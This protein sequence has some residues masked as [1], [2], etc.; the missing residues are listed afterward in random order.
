MKIMRRS[1]LATLLLMALASFASAQEFRGTLTGRVIDAQDAVIPNVKVTATEVST[2]ANYDTVSSASG[3]YTIPFL[4]PGTYRVTVSAPGFK[5]YVREGLVISTTERASLDIRLEIGA[6]VE[7]V[8]VAADTPLI[9]TATASTGQVLGSKQLEDMPANGRTPLILAQLAFGVIPT[10][11]PQFNHPFDDSG[12]SSFSVGGGASANNEILMDGAPDGNAAGRLAY[13]PPLDAVSEIKVDAFQSDA[14]YG[15]VGGGT[16]NTLTKAGT[17]SFHGSAYDY[18]QV[19]ALNATP[20][21][22][23]LAGQKK[24]VTRF[25][26]Y[27]ATLGG[28]VLIP[29]VFDGRNKVL[30]FFA[31][32]GIKNDT[33]GGSFVTVPTDAQKNGDFS[34][35][36]NL[37]STYKIYDPGTAVLNGSHV[38]RQPFPNNII[39]T[40]RINPV[41]QKLASY[42]G[43]PNVTS[44]LPDGGNNYFS[45]GLN[46]DAFDSELGRL[47]FNISDR[48]KIFY[49]F[50]HNDRYHTAN[51]VFNNVATGSILIQPNW[52]SMVDDVYTISPRMVLDTRFNYTRNVEWRGAGGDNFDFSQL[53][54]PAALVAASPRVGFPTLSASPYPSFGYNK[55]D[56]KPFDSFQIFT[57]ASRVT[58]KHTLKF[59]A[60][61]RLYRQ[62]AI[63]FGNSSGSYTF[64]TNWTGQAENSTAPSVGYQLASM[65]L[66]LPTSGSFDLNAFQTS[67]AGY[68]AFF[69]QDDFRPTST[70]TLNIGLRYE[71]DMPTQERYNRSVNGFDFSTASPINAAAQA[72]YAKNPIPQVPVGQFDAI[73]GLTFASPN[74]RGLYDTGAHNFSPRFGFAWSPAALG[75]RTVFRGGLGVFFDS[76]GVSSVNQTGFSAST[77]IVATLDGY[78]TPNV[79]LSNP[80]PSLLQPTGS[81]LGIATNL[82]QSVSFSAANQLAP[83]TLRWDFDIQ[84]QLSSKM[85]FEVGYFGDHAVHLGTSQNLNYIP[86]QYLSTLPTRDNDVVNLLTGNVAN[87]FAG[88]LPGT[89]LNGSTVALSQLLLPYPQFTG[90]SIS[91]LPA[92][93]SY[94]EMLEARFERQ[95]GHGVQFMANYLWSKSIERISRLNDSDPFLEKRISPEDRPQ[96]I[97][98]TGSWDLPFGHGKAISS[99]SAI[100]N[101]L[102]GG[103]N[104]NGVYVA[105][106]GAP[107]SWGNVIYLGG[108]LN[109]NPRGVNGAFDVT[110]FDT[111]SKDQLADNIRTFSSMFS[112]LRQDGTN[113]LDLS[114]VKNNP[115][116][117]KVNLQLRCEAFNSLN[118]PTFAAPNVSPTSSSFGRITSQ[119][120]IP[121]SLQLSLKL[122]W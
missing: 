99:S 103:W 82:G 4:A 122:L 37:G 87:P 74:D 27:G 62:S 8:T 26:Q 11:N 5:R 85:M 49:N 23:N 40:N 121:R 108:P 107:I 80:F 2:G 115:I 43:E 7:T 119:A 70:L 77:P 116:T 42:Y 47:D 57:T 60:D 110:R 106:P 14:A 16:V 39:P 32:E 88:L 35:L 38:L 79:T 91:G 113:S 17:N 66:G 67:Q 20:Y 59:G 102:I 64:G 55:W 68:Y 97:V 22:T 78:L 95:F 71:R 36:L 109:L 33:P 104:V 61:L 48:H 34:Q 31:Y 12:P 75:G 21:F 89:T 56:N 96:R 117:E 93:S 50:R 76:V 29:K 63:S 92:G 100:V 13:S 51:N 69:V 105:Q 25:N 65:L 52:G 118:H 9:E 15:H 28:P 46:T 24:S 98:L 81:S 86:R 30:F 18:M 83:Y 41:G 19:S 72:A 3:Q 112:N 45:P 101:R 114:V 111:N 120:N 6:Q 44:T 1:A 84:H 94:F 73:G 53:G 90:V 58:G 54:F 10:G